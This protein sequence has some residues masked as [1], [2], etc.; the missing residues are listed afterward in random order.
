ML[1]SF[2]EHDTDEE[3]RAIL[4]LDMSAAIAALARAAPATDFSH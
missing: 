1:E 3:F 2:E 4:L